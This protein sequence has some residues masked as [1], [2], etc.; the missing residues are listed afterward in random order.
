MQVAAI[1]L[2]ISDDEEPAARLDRA[3]GLIDVEASRGADV[4]MLPEIWL[5]GFFAFDRYAGLAQAI[6]GPVVEALA[7]AA[8]SG[9]VVLH[10]GSIVERS[11]EGLHNTSLLFGADGALLA[12]YRKV[13]LFPYGSQE[14]ELLT[15]GNEA[16]VVDLLGA[17]AGLATCYDLRYPELFRR[18][19]DRDAE[20]FL[21]VAGWPFPRIDAWRVLGRSRAIENQAALIA[22]NSAGRLADGWFCGGTYS[23]NAWGT[24]LGE[25]DDRAGVLRVDLNID[26][27]RAARADFPALSG[28]VLRDG[29]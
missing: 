13:H 24:V 10:G 9:G 3:L 11:A 16:V 1:Q 26:A 18:M 14:A 27:L 28:R 4:V 2:E 29:S 23:V 12:S 22:C 25:L 15:R 17:R 7:G 6:D 8:R 19:V 20:L 5:P 21:V